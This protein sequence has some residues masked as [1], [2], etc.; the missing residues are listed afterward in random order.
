[1]C[2]QNSRVAP[3]SHIS[4]TWSQSIKFERCYVSETVLGYSHLSYPHST[5]EYVKLEPYLKTTKVRKS[6]IC[7]WAISGGKPRLENQ[8][9]HVCSF[10]YRILL[11]FVEYDNSLQHVFVT[12]SYP[13][14]GYDIR[15]KS[16]LIYIHRRCSIGV[17]LKGR[18]RNR[19]NP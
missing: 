7:D 13:V 2:P 19:K 18:N 6:K 12:L 9:L 14:E 15:Q 5:E 16:I 3:T 8:A 11:Y 1:M 10:L 4:E 17:L